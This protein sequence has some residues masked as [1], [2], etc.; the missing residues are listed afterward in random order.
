MFDVSYFLEVLP[1]IASKLSVTLQLALSAT[2]LALI[3]G[4]IIAVIAYYKVK[5]LYPVTRVYVSLMRGTPIVAQLYFFYFGVAVYSTMVRDMTPLVAVTIVLSLNE[6]AFMSESIRGALLS[7]D[8]GQKEAAYSLGM[9]N[10]QLVRRIVIPQAVRVAL[11]PLFNDIINL[12]KLSSL[13]FMV[14]VAD[15]MGAAK[16]E[17][18]KSFRFFE[19]YAA[20]MVV[21]WA[22]ISIL[23]FAHKYLE[24]KCASA[25]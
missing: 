14:G 5:I 3:L 17:G 7:V 11:P 16:I 22:V 21:Y 15:I 19:V 2:V 20:V 25:Y 18:A 12:L 6:G 9:S 1:I 10:F 23:G 24:K 13:A 4:V 8:E